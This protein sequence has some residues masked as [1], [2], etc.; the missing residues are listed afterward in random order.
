MKR[1]I[2]T[3]KVIMVTMVL[4]MISTNVQAQEVHGWPYNYKGVML[5]GFYWDS[6]SK[7]KWKKLTAQADEICAAFDLVWIPQSGKAAND[8]SMGYD[9]KYWFP[10]GNQFSYTS[11]FGNEQELRDM[12]KAFKDR[13]TGT[14]ADVVLNHRGNLTNWVDFP[15]EVYNGS[16]YELKST[17]ICKDDDGGST[18]TWA[19]A[20]GYSL[21]SN[22]DQ[23]EG[24]SGMR[25]LDHQSSNVQKC[26]KAYL[27]MLLE[28]LGY[29]GFR[30]D[31]VKGYPAYY[32]GM[33]N[34]A[35]GVEYSV[36]EYFDG[37]SNIRNW[38]DG[39][40]VDGW[41][42]SA[43]FD[44]DFKYVVTTAANEGKW[45][46]LGN[47][48]YGNYPLVSSR[49]DNG[50]YR[51]WAITF[52]ENHD[53]EL[54]P[55]GSSNGNIVQNI[56]PANAYMMGMP[57]TPCVFYK[58][59]KDYKKEISAMIDV[60]KAAGI[61]N[62][63]YYVPF[64]TTDNCYVVCTGE[65]A[66][67]LKLATAIGNGAKNYTNDKYVKVLEG[68]NY[69][70]LMNKSLNTAWADKPS[71]NYDKAFSVKLTAVSSNTSAQLVYTTNGSNPTSS[72]TKV[73][74]GSSITIPLG[75]TTLKVGLLING[76]VSG[77][78]TRTYK[79]EEPAPFTPYTITINVCA[80]KVG[81]NDYV[82]FHS[83]GDE[84]TG[85]AWP[86]DKVTTTKTTTD[87]KKWFYKSYNITSADDYV[88]LV[89]SIGTAANANQNQTVDAND[90]TQDAWL[91]IS[92]TKD[93]TKYLINDVTASYTTAVGAITTQTEKTDN[94]WYNI[95]GQV[96]N[97]KP[98]QKGIYIN[99][100][101]KYIVK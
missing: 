88:N 96:L 24:W 5:Q 90:F 98:T 67:D 56:L 35:A 93:G 20:N 49:Y 59:W 12:I 36:G 13:G 47:Q 29:I 39:T 65:S 80:E 33:Y 19:N 34:K 70:F 94:R 58:H 72:S 3:C 40:K 73:S 83:W 69:A 25:D 76:T 44:F 48:N 79:V 75:E 101:K 41:P 22:N 54:R 18:L 55:D 64:Q 66:T 38:I 45:S 91:E 62:R 50:N 60:R 15:K 74:S 61:H 43:A 89:F 87:G 11:S 27:K 26:V 63:S 99:N 8:N 71:G 17:D 9:P 42:T 57:G 37:S 4:A 10:D 81:W 51:Q 21:S 68:S 32:T 52:V 77:I 84:R 30:Y 95:N 1:L 53:T 7:T 31:M 46:K 82:N 2:T 14:I 92:D 100:G 97:G 86:G 6:F 28:D 23:G 78:V 85:T 16:T